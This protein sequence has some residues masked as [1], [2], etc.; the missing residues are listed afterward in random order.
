M[1]KGSTIKYIGSLMSVSSDSNESETVVY[2]T[3]V[4]VQLTA[5]YSDGWPFENVVN[6]TQHLPYSLSNLIITY[7]NECNMSICP[8]LLLSLDSLCLVGNCS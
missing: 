7:F 3:A 5:I 1:A 6:P 8:F 4:T 2:S